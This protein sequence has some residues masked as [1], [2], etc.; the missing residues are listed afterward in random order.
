MVTMETGRPIG[1]TAC[2]IPNGF[3]A[4]ADIVKIILFESTSVTEFGANT[5]V[6]GVSSTVWKD[7][8]TV[9]TGAS[10]TGVILMVLVSDPVN[11]PSDAVV[12]KTQAA[13]LFNAVV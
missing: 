1:W 12:V 6:L 13:L 10:L 9:K 8:G 7:A 2:R 4:S 5:K 11:D 3:E